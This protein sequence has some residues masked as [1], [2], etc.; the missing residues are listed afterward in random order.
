VSPVIVDWNR[1]HA[2][3]AFVELGDVLVAESLLLDV[4]PGGTSLIEAGQGTLFAIAPRENFQD[5][6][7]GFSFISEGDAGEQFFNT[8]WPQRP[9]FPTFWL[10]VMEYF[11]GRVDEG[12]ERVARPGDTVEFTLPQT[13]Q[14]VTVISPSGIQ[15]NVVR[16]RL[17]L[18]QYQAT[19]ELGNYEVRHNDQTVYRFAVNLYDRDESD[20]ALRVQPSSEAE[21]GELAPVRIGFDEIE[22]EAG[23]RPV[24]REAWRWLLLAALAVLV[25]EWYIYNRRAYI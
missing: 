11:A 12:A 7:L 6:V 17:G 21:N 1:A 24:R 22:A 13:P 15:S 2:L 4:P 10:N 16:D 3:M 23:F 19:D 5:A 9:S 20:V 25:L 18:Y 8:D 14:R